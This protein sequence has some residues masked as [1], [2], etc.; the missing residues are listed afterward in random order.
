VTVIAMAVLAGLALWHGARRWPRRHARPAPSRRLHPPRRLAGALAL[1]AIAIVAPPAAGAL[2]VG[3]RLRR[4]LRQR[5]E[6]AARERRV[7]DALPDV[8]DLLVLASSAGLSLP[9]AHPI[10]A[11]HA[12]A[13]LHGPLTDAHVAAEAGRPRADALIAALSPLGDRARGLA[14]LLGDHL[15]Y[16]VPLLP[17]LERVSFE[18][19]LDRRRRAELAARRVPVQLL[20]PLVTCVLPAF[21]LLTVVPLLAAS[22]ESLPT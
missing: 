15:R 5:R 18:L 19:R 7:A 4:L 12:P 10:V 16:G 11:A 14:Q 2:V 13:P 8:V 20:G 9:L 6:E 21:C 22:L 3:W 17:A 1:V